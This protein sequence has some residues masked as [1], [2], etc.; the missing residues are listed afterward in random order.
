MIEA[1]SAEPH[2]Q[3]NNFWLHDRKLGQHKHLSA[4]DYCNA[5][6]RENIEPLFRFSCIRNPWDRLISVYFFWKG[7]GHIKS[8]KLDE[9]DPHEFE[10]MLKLPHAHTS[11]TKFLSIENKLFVDFLMRFESLD[12][13]FARVCEALGLSGVDLPHKNKSNH[14]PYRSYYDTRLKNIVAQL[15]EE[16][17]SI[18]KYSF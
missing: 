10:K 4:A 1:V 7:I 13:D 8:D 12:D 17:I 2:L 9:F 6:G 16:D 15:H 18:F 14:A 11:Y 5:Y 3:M